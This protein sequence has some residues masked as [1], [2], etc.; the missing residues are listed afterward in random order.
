MRKENEF[1]RVLRVGM[2]LV[3]S[4]GLAACA[5]EEEEELETPEPTTDVTTPAA[6]PITVD[7]ESVENSNVSGDATISRS[8]ESIMVA[9]TLENLPSAGPFQAQLVS[10]RCDADTN[11]STTPST[12][13]TTPGAPSTPGQT[14][15]PA[16][17]TTPGTESSRVLATLETIQV[18][19]T[20][21]AQNGMSHSTVP[22][23]SLQGATDAAIKVMEGTRTVACGNVN[24]INDLTMGGSTTTTPGTAPAR[25]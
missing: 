4:A 14:T 7:I 3:L 11:I 21:P 20:A 8:G 18:T 5:P 2:A 22:L 15:P 23:S 10:G 13:S 6:E 12:P 24:N 9:L 1:T 16:A 19:G 25:P 17:T